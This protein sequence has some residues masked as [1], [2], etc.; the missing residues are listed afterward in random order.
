M[1]IQ[2][3]HYISTGWVSRAELYFNNTKTNSLPIQPD[4]SNGRRWMKP[5]NTSDIVSP[6][7][8]VTTPINTRFA[9]GGLTFTW[10][11]Q[12][13][14]PKMVSY[15]HST[16][17]A[18]PIGNS[19]FYQRAYSN[20][21]TAQT[22]NRGSGE[23]ETYH[24]FCTFADLSQ[25]A[26]PSAG[27]YN[28][29]QL[30]FVATKI[31]PE[32]PSLAIIT[33]YAYTYTQM[34]YGNINVALDNIGDTNTF[35]NTKMLWAV[36]VGVT[37]IS[38]NNSNW[39]SNIEYSDDIGV[40]WSETPPS[41]IG[42]TTNIRITLNEEIGGGND[43]G[44][45]VFTI[46]PNADTIS[47]T[48]TFAGTT[49]GDSILSGNNVDTD[50]IAV[51]EFDISA[52]SPLL[53]LDAGQSV[54]RQINAPTPLVAINGSQVDGWIDLSGNNITY[55]Q[56]S[57]ENQP[58]LV[59]G[60]Q[61][62]KRAIQFDGITDRLTS[63]HFGLDSENTSLFLVVTPTNSSSSPGFEGIFSTVDYNNVW[64]HKTDTTT[65]TQP[66]ILMG[67]SSFAPGQVW[68]KS[69][70]ANSGFQILEFF[71]NNGTMTLYRDTILLGTDNTATHDMWG[72]RRSSV[73]RG[74]NIIGTFGYFDGYVYEIIGFNR[75]LN[76]NDR[77]AIEYY[78]INKYNH[79]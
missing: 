56:P 26:E 39:A 35:N 23:W 5:N 8:F 17:F 71:T 69:G 43:T 3:G 50:V 58:I 32:G 27:G 33:N 42:N 45:F 28:N 37:L 63:G 29:V 53:W 15:I 36:P 18:P 46:R 48:S 65:L 13:M 62:G 2:A 66:G 10:G 41:P 54:Y 22:W 52:M 74:A 73:G 34:L 60:L 30:K 20:K 24:T 21:I 16:F 12:N 79:V 44:Y 61:N 64:A 55:V 4:M 31:A 40:T 38:I 70:T 9:Y 19:S 78:L 59:T 77:Q 7:K 47:F 49:D 57:S 75:T 6:S 68:L 76:T 25:E 1:A 14:S 11:L 72:I 67:R 51:D